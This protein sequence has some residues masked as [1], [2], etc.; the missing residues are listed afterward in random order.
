MS[1]EGTDEIVRFEIDALRRNCP[2]GIY[3]NDEFTALPCDFTLSDN[4]EIYYDARDDIWC[5]S[6][7]L[8]SRMNIK[9]SEWLD[10]LYFRNGWYSVVSFKEYMIDK[11]NLQSQSE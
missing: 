4:G 3:L 5:V 8:N 10:H 11:Y 7:V 2:F 9:K 1:I 6:D